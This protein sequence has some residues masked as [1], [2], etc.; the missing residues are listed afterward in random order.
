MLK[1]PKKEIIKKDRPVAIDLDSASIQQYWNLKYMEHFGYSQNLGLREMAFLKKM[2][3]EIDN[4][5]DVI[6]KLFKDWSKFKEVNHWIT[7]SSPSADLMVRFKNKI[8]DFYYST[9]EKK[10]STLHKLNLTETTSDVK[11]RLENV[12]KAEENI[13]KMMKQFQA[14]RDSELDKL[15]KAWRELEDVENSG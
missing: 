8:L 13:I 3:S 15:R 9:K 2:D 5:R 1:R 10:V 7:D 14:Y 6:E 4:F 12:V 11:I